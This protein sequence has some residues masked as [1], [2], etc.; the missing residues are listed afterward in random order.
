MWYFRSMKERVDTLILKK[1]FESDEPIS[2][3]NLAFSLGVSEKTALKYLN[4]LKEDIVDHGATIEIKQGA[5]SYLV[6]HDKD[7][8][9]TY[10][11]EQT[12]DIFNDPILRKKFVLF[13]LI[14]DETYVNVYDL[15]D[16]LAISPSSLRN[17]IKEIAPIIDKYN[18]TLDHSHTHGYRVIGDEK[19]MRQCIAKEC[20]E[21]IDLDDFLSNSDLQ[22][23]DVQKIEE[24][25]NES[26]ENFNI[27][28][29]H[30]AISALT[31][32]ILIAINRIETDNTIVVSD[33]LLSIRSSPE[34][35]AVNSFAKK[36]GQEFG[37]EFPDNEKLYLT[38]HINGKQRIYGHE[39]I[40][41][42]VDQEALIFYNKFLRNILD[43][44]N[45]DF[46]EDEDLRVSLLNHIVPFLNRVNNN[47]QIDK[48]EIINAKNEFPYAYE[49]AL[50]GM[51]YFKDKGIT[52]SPC[53]ISY[54]ALHIAL[55][56]EKAKESKK[57]FNIVVVC[58]DVSSVFRIITY[59]L[60]KSFEG[61]INTIKFITPSDIE[62]F[63]FTDYQLI[64]NTSG[65]MIRVQL[66][67][68]DVSSTLSFNDINLIHQALDN[69]EVSDEMHE[70][71]RPDLF[72]TFEAK[73]KQEA[74]YKLASNIND[75]IK[76][77][78]DFLYRI[79]QREEL[80]TTE[81]DNRI[82][83]PHPLSSEG[84]QSFVSVAKLT[85]PI[86][87][88][89]KNIQLIFLCT[90]NGMYTAEKS[91]F[92]KISKC[93]ADDALVQSLINAKTYEEF[94]DIFVNI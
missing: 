6:I 9:Y 65:K 23:H 77:P 50:Y 31:L 79:N 14:T 67:T 32:H 68:I 39:K 87:W 89:N 82:A 61:R 55:A 64:L 78:E 74:L 93:I 92:D 80:E 3:S 4:L 28:L 8:F 37:I 15:S 75:V 72:F 43:L 40:Q 48:A 30:E 63:D 35:F 81:Y 29:S 33:K 52:I 25:L 66:P 83:I 1:L 5:G 10:I 49:M 91:F 51:Q 22:K 88:Q 44:G 26:L 20:K 86:K 53:E 85:K 36:I 71:I 12:N 7:K 46:F 24:I 90:L 54:F 58:N 19:N 16:E 76:L 17:I 41:V 42:K 94:M 18:L 38:I 73:D 84:V 57:K 21:N 27:A 60:N 34:Y 56:L 70:L 69:G 11:H 62:T 59:K 2:S 13:R 45:R 47:M